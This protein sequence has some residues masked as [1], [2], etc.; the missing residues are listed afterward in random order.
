MTQEIEAIQSEAIVAIDSA[1]TEAL[2][3][4]ARIAFLGKKGKLTAASANMKTC[5]PEE[6]PALGQALNQARQAIN[7]ALDSKKTALQDEADR[8]S[9]EGLDLTLPARKFYAVWG[10]L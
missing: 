3:E 9:V 10:S 5:P 1:N 8:K 7:G 2:L 4:E 6:K